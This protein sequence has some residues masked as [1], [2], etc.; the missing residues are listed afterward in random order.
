MKHQLISSR[1][2]IYIVKNKK[3]LILWIKYLVFHCL[4]TFVVL[5]FIVFF[6]YSLFLRRRFKKLSN[7]DWVNHLISMWGVSYINITYSWI[8]VITELDLFALANKEE[9]NTQVRVGVTFDIHGLY[10]PLE[11]TWTSLGLAFII[12][13]AIKWNFGKHTGIKHEEKH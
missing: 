2:R 3:L 11:W 1:F 13:G 7:A 5:F 8:L 9:N 4:N 6:S 10:K 12:F